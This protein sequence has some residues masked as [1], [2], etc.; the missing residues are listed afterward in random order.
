MDELRLDGKT[1]LVTGAGRGLGR[2]YAHL[3]ATRGANVVVN[4]FGTELDGSGE[5][6]A[7]AALV[8]AEIRRTGGRAVANFDSVA[9][10]EGARRMVKQAI[11][12]FGGLHVII[13]NAGNFTPERSF[14]ETSSES[15][16]SLLQVHLM[17]SVNTARAAWPHLVAQRSGRIVNVGSHAGYLGH[18]GRFEY[19]SAKGAIHGFTLS[20]AMEGESHGIAANVLAPGAGTRPVRSWDDQTIFATEAFAPELAAP[21]ALW[22]AHEHC[23]VTGCAIAVVAGA[24]T[25]LVVAETHGFQSRTPT[26]EAIIAHLGAILDPGDVSGSNLGLPVGAVERGAE[27]VGRFFTLPAESI[28]S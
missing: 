14:L 19:A 2:A 18:R 1:V 22:L 21:T 3:L 4:D 24:T 12:T 28:A 7:P 8:V 15:F 11:D 16:L 26:P 13:N 10:E 6:A 23:D 20:L 27:L 5:D 9:S 17:G 25:R